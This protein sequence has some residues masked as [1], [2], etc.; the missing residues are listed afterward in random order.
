MISLNIL[1]RAPQP[2]FSKTRLIP[3]LGA[4]GAARA[5]ISLLH[6]V[7][8]VTRSWCEKR[9]NRL[10]RL[11][12][13]PQSSVSFFQELAPQE[14]L[15]LQPEGDLGARLDYVVR[16]GLREATAVMVIGGLTPYRNQPRQAVLAPAA[17]GGYV[18]VGLHE[19]PSDLF[20]D[21]PWGSFD[22]ARVTRDR[23]LKHGMAWQELEGHWDVDTPTDWQRFQKMLTM[24]DKSPIF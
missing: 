22:V 9:S 4:D 3:L 2:G 12:Y 21:I 17:D 24:K 23:F 20:E 13:T 18:L 16:Q 19:V 6:H 8:A 10:F 1:C 11:W 15:R 14:W 7:V 5:Q